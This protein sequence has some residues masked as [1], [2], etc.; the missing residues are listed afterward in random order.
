MKVRVA[1]YAIVGIALVACGP[2]ERPSERPAPHANM[3]GDYACKADCSGHKAGYD[4]AQ[5]ND[6][7]DDDDCTGNSRSFIE[8]CKQ[9]VS[10]YQDYEQD[11]ANSDNEG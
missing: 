2:S 4:W 1:I 3:F 6:I 10:E 9:W 7:N 8:G 5:D 11:P